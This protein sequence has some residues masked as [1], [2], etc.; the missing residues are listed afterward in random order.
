MLGDIINNKFFFLKNKY[1]AL[2][3][4]S[5]SDVLQS[6][7]ISWLNDESLHTNNQQHRYPVSVDTQIE[8]VKNSHARGDILLGIIELSSENF[9]G[10]ITLK[11]INLINRNAE[12]AGL[13][14]S[15]TRNKPEI[16]IS[17]WS[18]LLKHGFEQINL[19]KIYGG[20]INFTNYD[21]LRYLFNFQKE[22]IRS[23]HVFKNGEYVDIILFSVF[24][25][26]VKYPRL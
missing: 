9:C 15:Y 23:S 14:N 18:L 3:V 17:A 13:Q 16:F 11:N 24:N 1:V 8:F 10:V 5:E 19:F 26:S 4:L 21:A 20:A 22:G 7:W 6:E 2:K 25:N 12:I